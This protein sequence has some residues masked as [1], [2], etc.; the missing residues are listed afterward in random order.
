MLLR[1]AN[2]VT[3]CHDAARDPPRIGVRVNEGVAGPSLRDAL[4]N[5][6]PADPWLGEP[7]VMDGQDRSQGRRRHA[8]ELKANGGMTAAHDDAVES[9]FISAGFPASPRN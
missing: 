7:S 4:V 9:A 1:P 2:R 5:Q 3:D 8:E 6:R